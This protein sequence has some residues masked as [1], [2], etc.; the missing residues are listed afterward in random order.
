ML[1]VIRSEGVE[2]W[3]VICL[4]NWIGRMCMFGLVVL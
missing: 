3:R 1:G 2:C 4:G